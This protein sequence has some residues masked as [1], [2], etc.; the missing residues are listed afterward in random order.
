MGQKEKPTGRDVR[1]FENTPVW[2]VALAIRDQD[3]AK[4]KKLLK[5][6]PLSFINFKEKY[7]GQSLLNWAVYRDNYESAKILVE[8]GADPNLK[9]ND[10][11]S[12][13]IHAAD[14]IETSDYLKLML[15]YGGDPNTVADIDAP[16]HLRTP[17]MAAAFK[18]LENVKILVNAGA[19]PN[20]IYKMKRGNIGGEII[21]S[22]LIYAFYGKRIDVVEYLLVETKVEFNY[23]FSTNIEG[24]PHH[25]LYYLRDLVYPLD[26]NEYKIKMEVV[27]Y[28]R[29]KGLDYSKEPIPELYKKQYDKLFLEKY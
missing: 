19:D 24:R 17:L 29:T 6:K 7:Y 2:E 27:N 21:Q 20:F 8:A 22:A 15:K 5:G 28:L 13:V 23:V 25:I 1:V 14:K 3:N 11:T 4:V 10:S 26:S 18:R 12:A 16:Q 9:R